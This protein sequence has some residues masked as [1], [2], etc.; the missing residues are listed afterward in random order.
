MLRE[1][2]KAPLFH[3]QHIL[4]FSV[5]WNTLLHVAKFGKRFRNLRHLVHVSIQSSLKQRAVVYV[6]LNSEFMS[7][8]TLHLSGLN[9]SMEGKDILN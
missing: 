3:K 1:E 6:R 5:F 8:L 9:Q 4:N 7:V 2:K